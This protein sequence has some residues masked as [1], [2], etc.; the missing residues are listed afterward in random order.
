MST[1]LPPRRFSPMSQLAT[2]YPVDFYKESTTPI[3]PTLAELKFG[4]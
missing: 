4:Q 3:T 1:Q 2:D